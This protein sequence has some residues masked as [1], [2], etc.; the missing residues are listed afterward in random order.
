MQKSDAQASAQPAQTEQEP[1]IAQEQRQLS[2][3]PVPPTALIGRSHE[4]L[5]AQHALD[6]PHTRLLT[7]T[8]PGGVGKTR[9]SLEIAHRIAH[10]FAHGATFVSL[11]PLN[12]PTLV[13]ASIAAALGLREEAATSL[14]DRLKLFLRDR[15]YLL[16]LDNFEQVIQAA[17]LLVELLSAAPQLHIIVSSRAALRVRGEHELP[18]HPLQLPDPAHTAQHEV[19]ADSMALFVQA[20]TAVDPLFKLSQNNHATVAEICRRLDGLPLAIELA[21]AR[22]RM[23]SVQSILARLGNRLGLLTGGA[24]DLP[25]RQQTLRDAIA[26]SYELLLEH[27]RRVFRRLATFSA[28]CTL[29]AAEEVCQLQE[30]AGMD[31]METLGSL[32]EKSMVYRK[33][34]QQSEERFAMLETIREY[35][36]EMLR[37][38]DEEHTIRSRH[39]QY[40][41]ALA[42]KGIVGLI[43]P[44]QKE[45]LQIYAHEHDNFRSALAWLKDTGQNALMLELAGML[46]HFWLMHSHLSE[47]R[48]WLALA[49]AAGGENAPL[50]IQANVL[51][52]YGNI[53]AAMGDLALARQ[54]YEQS[55]EIYRQ[56]DKL[57]Q[58]GVL[59]S[60]IGN[61]ALALGDVPRARELFEQS[62]EIRRTL[63]D[64]KG[65]AGA[66]NNLGNILQILEEYEIS[67]AFYE[68]ALEIYQKLGSPQGILFSLTNMGILAHVLGDIEQAGTLY[69]Q[70]LELARELAN[71]RAEATLL[72][73][74][75]RWQHDR[76]SLDE[77][78]HLHKESFALFQAIGDRNGAAQAQTNLGRVARSMG[79][80]VEA[81]ELFRNALA[82][83]VET[84]D[85]IDMPTLLIAI[86]ELLA[87]PRGHEVAVQLSGAAATLKK[88]TGATTENDTEEQSLVRERLQPSLDEETFQWAW[89]R[90]SQMNTEEAVE[91][92]MNI[93]PAWLA[94]NPPAMPMA[95]LATTHAAATEHP[96]EQ[97][98]AAPLTPRELDVLRLLVDGQT[99]ADI[100]KKLFISTRTVN[101]HL[102]SVYSKLHVSS[103]KEAVRK[104]IWHRLV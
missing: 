53:L 35:A 77:A 67:R 14:I 34:G 6:Q 15:N 86:G 47:G 2:N 40:F 10:T 4:L 73:H 12:D 22:V 90:G 96:P 20:A 16:I 71:R 43:G 28:G 64:T 37:E 97:P 5:S 24:R 44:Q 63:G 30:E 68:E 104:A 87:G 56:Q 58:V 84:G 11:A 26:W 66:L 80:T 3:L 69:Q 100:G 98:L 76:K 78:W 79:R 93:N 8:G 48:R 103:R 57:P 23:L 92:A 7:L 72:N 59:I 38:A 70:S 27:E 31:M 95:A 52:H 61:M 65:V 45:W 21:A 91:L 50:E 101:A 19:I 33:Q 9:L 18:L 102:R 83:M 17:P 94:M 41:I 25:A 99:D 39:A 36:L 46:G 81:Y 54:Q 82:I 1:K 74:L 60:N 62:L 85:R 89:E 75:G 13:L 49:L 32:L 51:N 88:A 55:L 42:R 29:E